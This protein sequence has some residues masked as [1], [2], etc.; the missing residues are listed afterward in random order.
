MPEIIS[1]HQILLQLNSQL[2][3]RFLKLL[4]RNIDT[5]Y[6]PQPPSPPPLPTSVQNNTTNDPS[7]LL[8]TTSPSIHLTTSVTSTPIITTLEESISKIPQTPIDNI[9]AQ[10]RENGIDTSI[11]KKFDATKGVTSKWNFVLSNP[12]ILS[13][14]LLPR[15]VVLS[16]L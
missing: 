3:K 10:F 4:T 14:R 8:I 15:M 9:K 5:E 12:F 11:L 2:Q 6:S 13:V 7:P 16:S 1:E